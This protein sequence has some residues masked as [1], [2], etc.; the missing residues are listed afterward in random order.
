MGKYPP[1]L[2]PI[3]SQSQNNIYEQSNI[4]LP[5][6]EPSSPK[7]IMYV[8]NPFGQPQPQIVQPISQFTQPIPYQ[9]PQVSPQYPPF[10]QLNPTISYQ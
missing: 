6:S 1:T 9:L 5:I 4:Q 2:P 3:M 7:Q 8:S 10:P